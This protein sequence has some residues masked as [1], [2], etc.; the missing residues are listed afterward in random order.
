MIIGAEVSEFGEQDEEFVCFTIPT[1]E[2]VKVLWNAENFEDLVSKR[3]WGDNEQKDSFFKDN[4]I[5]AGKALGIEVYPQ[6]SISW[7]YPE[8]YGLLSFEKIATQAKDVK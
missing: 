1:D 5:E 4:K 8:M 2:Y 3:M 6:D 7:E